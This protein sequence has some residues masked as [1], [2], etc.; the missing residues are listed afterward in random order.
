MPQNSL[1]V[2]LHPCLIYYR[3]FY[4]YANKPCLHSL[5]TVQRS[6]RLSN[7]D[8]IRYKVVRDVRNSS[9]FKMHFFSLVHCSF[10]EEILMS[11]HGLSIKNNIKSMIFT[12]GGFKSPHHTTNAQTGRLSGTNTDKRRETTMKIPQCCLYYQRIHSN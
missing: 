8:V 4:E 12:T 10:K 5:T 1:N 11:L 7:I 9:D 2:T 3:Q 6:T